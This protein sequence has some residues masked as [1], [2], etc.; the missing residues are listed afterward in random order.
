[1]MCIVANITGQYGNHGQV[2]LRTSSVAALAKKQPM[3]ATWLNCWHKQF[4]ITQAHKHSV[5]Q[6]M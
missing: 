2:Q 5:I 6:S 3:E 4:Y 1:M